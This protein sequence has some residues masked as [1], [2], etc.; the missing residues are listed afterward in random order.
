MQL[1]ELRREIQDMEEAV[2]GSIDPTHRLI[3]YRLELLEG[4]LR[5]INDSLSGLDRRVQHLEH[6]AKY[7]RWAF[8]GAGVVVT[9]IVRE[10]GPPLFR[11]L[12]KSAS[13]AFIQTVM[14]G[15]G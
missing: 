11:L 2:G 8:A 1:Q 14:M 3:L 15:L 7:T 5:N 4:S 13:E 9:L 12:T 10:F 6:D